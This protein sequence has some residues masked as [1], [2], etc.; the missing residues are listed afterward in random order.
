MFAAGLIDET[1][2][3]LSEHGELGRTASQAVGYSETIAH[4]RGEQDLAAT[5]QLVKNR[6]HQFAR[7]QETWF[8]SLSECRWVEM[9]PD[10]AP[11]TTAERIANST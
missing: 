1:R 10:E 3:L 11:K 8:R 2:R 6:T 4:L 5:K 9:T 7:R